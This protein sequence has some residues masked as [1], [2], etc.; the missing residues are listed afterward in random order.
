MSFYFIFPTYEEADAARPNFDSDDYK[1][2]MDQSED[3]ERKERESFDRCDTD[4]C[5]T[6]WLHTCSASDAREA[7]RL[8]NHG[9]LSIFKVLLDAE[10]GEL[11]AHTPLI[12][13]SRYHYGHEWKW[14]VKRNGR[15]E[16]VTDY[17]R[18]K[19]FTD[20]GL[21]VAWMLAPAKMYYRYPGDRRPE[22]RGLSGLASYNGK[23]SWIDYGAAGLEH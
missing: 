10:T 1:R 11:V 23:T 18:E 16:W 5:V 17:K 21:R 15:T 4:G 7:A 22:Q 6:Q 12:F 9:N 2:F 20:R 19:N 8:S 14:A 3:Y 13:Q